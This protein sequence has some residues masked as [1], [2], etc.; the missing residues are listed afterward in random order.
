M[1]ARSR[2]LAACL[3]LALASLAWNAAAVAQS[4]PKRYQNT[5]RELESELSAF[6]RRLPPVSAGKT[7]IRAATLSSANCQRGEIMLNDAERDAALRE[8]D[9][10]KSTGADGIVLQVCYPLLTPAFRDPQPF[11]DYYA[12]L[13]NA[14][15]ARD[16]KLLVEHV[17]LL[18]AYASVDAR[19]Y[20][21]KLT[22]QRFAKERFDELKTIL[23]A[24][25]PDY[26]TLVSE[27]RTQ[28]A[29]LQ[30]TVKDWRSYVQRSVESLTQQLG[31]FPTL[32][33]AGS[34]LWE[35]FGYVEAFAG[36]KG[37]G[38]IDLHLFP[39][40]AGGQ[41]NLDRLMEWPDR[42]RRIDPDKRIVV[43]EFWLY[44]SGVAETFKLPLDLNASARNVFSF[45]GPLDQKFLRVV[46]V[47]AR[48][49]GIELIAPFW[50][51]YFFAYVDYNDPLTFRLNAKDL[52]GLA[53]Q[54]AYEAIQRGQVTDTGLV[55]RDM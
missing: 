27:P 54:R 41:N 43:S 7:P 55:F 22:K 13:A 53:N 8:L 46:G 30:L 11:L 26:L 28:S 33:G 38:Y 17:A 5:Y 48:E 39:I 37:L 20:Y 12:N 14:V 21:A 15:R 52:M 45:W 25:Q 36:I 32:L 16:M 19:P 40:A 23:L 34:G 47:A 9:A 50:S 3:T 18:P 51:R 35:D 10:L 31:S 4:A 42:I 24:L 6:Q 49:K 29:G 44:K 1:S 2:R